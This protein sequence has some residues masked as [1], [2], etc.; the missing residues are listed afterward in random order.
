MAHDWVP[1]IHDEERVYTF[2]GIDELA[3]DFAAGR[4]TSY[5]PV[6]EINPA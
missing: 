5:F 2:D 3:E 4:V 1:T 6:F